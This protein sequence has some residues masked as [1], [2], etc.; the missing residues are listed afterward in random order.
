MPSGPGRSAGRARQPIEG[1]TI[2]VSDVVDDPDW[3]DFVDALPGSH[4]QSSAWAATKSALGWRA[5]RVVATRGTR[6]VAGCQVLLRPV[7]LVGSLGYASRGPL[8]ADP[9]GPAPAVVLDEL[10]RVAR[11]ER[12]LL[13]KVQPPPGGDHL[14][15]ALAARGFRPSPLEA[16]P[17]A[18]VRIDLSLPPEELWRRMRSNVRSNIGKAQRKGVVVRAGERGDLE[19]FHQLVVSTGQRQEF[20]PYPLRYYERMWESFAG[21][22]RIRLLLAEHEGRTL[23]AVLLV[24]FGDTV[25]YV[26]G[27]RAAE[28]TGIHPVELTHWTGV[29]WATE[30]GYRYY[31]FGGVDPAFAGALLRGEAT[32]RDATGVA[33]FKLGFGGDVVLFPGAYDRSYRPLLGTGL[34][35]A[36]SH[37]LRQRRLVGRVLGRHG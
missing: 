32:P 1:F 28:Q 22:G 26:M 9:D 7:P 20:A 6:I 14:V 21:T 4:V 11:A 33:R 10:D 13:L 27:G 12:L 8:V 25:A 15:P 35:L 30:R 16:A 3:D 37:L 19:A 5:L 31:D 17:T 18:T 36:T 2:R 23:A 24:G 29:E 34:R